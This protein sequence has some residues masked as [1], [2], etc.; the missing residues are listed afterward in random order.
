L[1]HN[2]LSFIDRNTAELRK[3]IIHLLRRSL[4]YLAL[5]LL[6]V[7]TLLPFLWLIISSLKPSTAIFSEIPR[8]IPR[9]VTLENYLWAFGPKGVDFLELF[10]NTLIVSSLSALLSGTLSSLAAYGL[11][12]F[13]FPGYR[14]TGI[15]ILVFQMFT[16][17]VVIVSWYN[18][19][20]VF[21]IY[22]TYIVLILAYTAFT[23]PVITWL[24]RGYFQD[25]PEA[26]EEAALVDGCNKLQALYHVVLPVAAPGLITSVLF[27][28]VLSWNDYIY[29]LSLA[30][31]NAKTL[32][33]GIGELVGF[34][35]QTQWGGVMAS[36]VLTALPVVIIFIFLQK[37]L[38]SGLTA[39]AVK[40]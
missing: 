38:V 18:I 28:F 15:F 14:I 21:N 30:G 4:L 20:Q 25:I 17:P 33:V 36:G 12:R 19:A 22:D 23:S 16:G 7:F 2:K 10:K 39:G 3:S 1:R 13:R 11:S 26:L 8:W 5:L 40:E 37:R 27:A 24:L 34:F 29:A 9:N 6:S 32:Q 31:K 35:G